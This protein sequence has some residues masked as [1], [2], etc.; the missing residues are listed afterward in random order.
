AALLALW[1]R[2]LTPDGALIVADVIPPTVGVASDAL[3]LI[4][5]GAA[6]GFLIAAL[7][8]LIRTAASSY[9]RLH[10]TLSKAHYGEAEFLVILRDAGFA[11]ERLSRNMEH[12]QARM[13]FRARP[14]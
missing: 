8:G 5:Y 14:A 10:L 9:R 7:A 3:A 12:N 1:R 13:T 11:A 6:R 4:R 2:L